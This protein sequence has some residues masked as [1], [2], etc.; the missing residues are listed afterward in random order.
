ETFR[1]EGLDILTLEREFVREYRI[2]EPQTAQEVIGFYARLIAQEVKLPSQFAVLAPKVRVF[3]E[4]EAFGRR[5]DLEAAEMVR[6]IAQPLVGHVVRKEFVKVLRPLL[7]EDQ[8][9]ELTGMP[10]R[11]SETPG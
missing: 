2:P 8:V 1:Y 6:A 9:P 3:L 4:T 7:V 11:L 10:R 5:V